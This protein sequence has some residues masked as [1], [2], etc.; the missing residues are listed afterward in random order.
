[1]T[2]TFPY[3][4]G[5]KK[6][7]RVAVGYNQ[8]GKLDDYNSSVMFGDGGLYSTAEDLLKWDQALH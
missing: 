5:D 8:F 6:I 2:R 4:N 3:P 7:D 1:M